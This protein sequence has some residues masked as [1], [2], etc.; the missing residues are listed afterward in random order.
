[1]GDASGKVVEKPIKKS[2]VRKDTAKLEAPDEL[3]SMITDPTNSDS[4]SELELS[5]FADLRGV[6]SELSSLL[7]NLDQDLAT[8]EANLGGL[9]FDEFEFDL[10]DNNSTG[11]DVLNDDSIDFDEALRGI[12]SGDFDMTQFLSPEDAASIEDIESSG[13]SDDGRRGGMKADKESRT[14]DSVIDD[15]LKKAMDDVEEAVEE[16]NLEDE[17]LK[18]DE[19]DGLGRDLMIEDDEDL[20]LDFV[21]DTEDEDDDEYDEEDIKLPSRKKSV[22]SLST[23]TAKATTA[24]SSLDEGSSSEAQEDSVSPMI[25]EDVSTNVDELNEKDAPLVIDGKEIET[26]GVETPPLEEFKRLMESLGSES[27]FEDDEMFDS[28]E[29]DDQPAPHDVQ[30]VEE[31]EEDKAWLPQIYQGGDADEARITPNKLNA[32]ESNDHWEWWAHY[33]DRPANFRVQIV[34][35]ITNSSTNSSA[36]DIVNKIYDYI[37]EG[38]N[39]DDRINYQIINYGY[40]EQDEKYDENGN[41]L[42]ATDIAPA[43]ELENNLQMWLESYNTYHLIDGMAMKDV[44]GA[45][46]PHIIYSP[47]NLEA[48]LDQVKWALAEDELDGVLL[49]PRMRKIRFRGGAGKMVTGVNTEFLDAEFSVVDVR[50][51]PTYPYQGGGM[52]FKSADEEEKPQYEEMSK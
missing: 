7:P 44:W 41:Y 35:V 17:E 10:G 2:V 45:I 15:K 51:E 29:N 18:D 38:T 12:E 52:R 49:P 8:L 40:T 33:D 37:K 48:I 27:M 3:E 6:E 13:S 34:S 16:N 46:M 19:D 25:Y 22:K 5:K 21:V 32:S 24:G 28:E 43:A 47:K 39:Y 20:G 23:A 14:Q 26:L 42:E 36:I 1:M 4:L 31:T 30:V 11:V 50:T 9:D